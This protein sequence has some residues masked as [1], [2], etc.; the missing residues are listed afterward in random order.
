MRSYYTIH[1]TSAPVQGLGESLLLAFDN[2]LERQRGVAAPIA[3]ASLVTG[4]LRLTASVA[5][6][7]PEVALTKARYA[8]EGALRAAGV[9][10]PKVIEAEIESRQ[11]T[12]DRH[13]LVTG[14]EVARRIGVSRERVRQM[15]SRTGRFPP[16]A[17]VVGGYRIWRWGDVVDWAAIEGRSLQL[18]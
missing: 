5:A 3:A 1:L 10:N 9:R 16:A 17:A 12:G 6:R 15:V 4:T 18:G 2:A 13:E 8:F 11:E 14:A 7:K